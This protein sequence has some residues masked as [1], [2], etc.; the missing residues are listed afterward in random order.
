MKNEGILSMVIQGPFWLVGM[1]VGGNKVF[2]PRIYRIIPD[3]D[4]PEPNPQKKRQ[5]I[6]LE[7]LPHFPPHVSFSSGLT[8]PI[9]DREVNLIKLY[10]QV[11]SPEA[12][13]TYNPNPA[14]PVHNPAI[15]KG[16]S[17]IILP[18]GN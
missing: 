8:Y 3:P 13:A 18:G 9:L 10:E 6:R 4:D 1:L 12:E 16:R 7:P 2:K 5:L 11:T 17:G 14:P 15:V